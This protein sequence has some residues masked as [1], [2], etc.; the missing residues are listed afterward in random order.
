MRT[1]I[2]D[3]KGFTTGEYRAESDNKA[4]EHA[5]AHFTNDFTKGMVEVWDVEADILVAATRFATVTIEEG[6]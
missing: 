6:R 3:C 2:A 4:V 5:V 1:Y